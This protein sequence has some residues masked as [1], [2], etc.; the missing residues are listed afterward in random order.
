M[1]MSKKY[2]AQDSGSAELYL[3]GLSFFMFPTLNREELQIY[4]RKLRL[5]GC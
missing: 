5:M 3:I 4:K 2:L 1:K